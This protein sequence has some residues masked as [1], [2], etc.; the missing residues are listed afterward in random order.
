MN[1]FSSKVFAR[2]GAV[3]AAGLLIGLSVPAVATA[4]DPTQLGSPLANALQGQLRDGSGLQIVALV[5]GGTEADG[6]AL[7]RIPGSSEPVLLRRGAS[8][9]LSQSGVPLRLDVTSVGAGGIELSGSSLQSPIV[10]QPSILPGGGA[11]S[12]ERGLLRLVEFNQVPLASALRLLADQTGRNFTASPAAAQTEVSLCL[13]NVTP[14][15]VLGQVCAAHR[16]WMPP[17]AAAGASGQPAPVRIQTLDEFEAS[18]SSFQ[19]SEQLSKAYVL[20][21]PNA[22]E[23]ASVIYGLYRD[24]V[25]LYLGDDDI[26]DDDI[27]DLSRRFD[28]LNMLSSGVSDLVEGFTPGNAGGSGGSGSSSVFSQTADGNWHKLSAD[29][30]D[31]A[32]GAGPIR[33]LSSDEARVIAAAATPDAVSAVAP[34]GADAAAILADARLTPPA[35][36]VTIARRSNMLIVRCVDP[37]IMADIDALIQK[38]DVPS[39]MVLLDL[40]VLEVSLGDSLE[41]IFDYKGSD[42][43]LYHH[44]ERKGVVEGS[45]PATSLLEN[46]LTFSVLTQKLFARIQ[47]LNDRG[48][49]RVLATPSLLTVNNEASQLFMG[50]E[51]P[52][53]RNVSATTYLNGD[54]VVSVP[55]TDF[56]FK[57][58]GTSLLITPNVNANGTVTL[59]LLEENSMLS[60]SKASIPVYG[61]NGALQYFDVD[62]IESRSVAGT[63]VAQDRQ[64]I[65]IGGMVREETSDERIGIPLLMDIPLLGWFFRSTKQVTRRSELLILVTPYVIAS[66]GEALVATQDYARENLEFDDSRAAAGVPP[67]D[68]DNNAKEQDP[69]K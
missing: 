16:L 39:P 38:L 28:R 34:A 26:L 3:L 36:F 64:T 44:D 15:D 53:V 60:A 10:L 25:R 6:V 48:K 2:G 32:R 65:A 42:P 63:F 35:I 18:L 58:V 43:F 7:V 66:P 45:L 27:N 5:A 52:I 1:M 29:E 55:T 67:P 37:R 21:Y 68:D 22:T 17:A 51:V 23:V 4:Q 59:R 57:R 50:K 61:E 12:D 14:D 33:R 30:A 49:A 69:K 62:V 8:V 24:R 40:R 20:L 19:Q 11:E 46:G 56:E 47:L 41:A 13:R 54:N 9:T 31:L